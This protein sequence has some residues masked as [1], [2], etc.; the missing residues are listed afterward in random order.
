MLCR[1]DSSLSQ[2][3]LGEEGARCKTSL[4]R[5]TETLIIKLE[6]SQTQAEQLRKYDRSRRNGNM[7]L[8][9]PFCFRE[10]FPAIE[11]ERVR[12]IALSA[13]M[14]MSYMRAQDDT[15]DRNTSVDPLILFVRDLYLRE[16]LHLLYALFPAE[17][18]FW[19]SYS[20][21]FNQ[22][23]TSVLR[24]T[25]NH[26]AARSQY[27][28]EE[29]CAIAKGKAA[30]AK[31]PVAAL[32]ELSGSSEKVSL[33][34]ES[35]DCFHVGY[36]YWDDVVDWK[37]DLAASKY[38]LLLSR[39][40]ERSTSEDLNVSADRLQEIIGCAVYFGGLAESNLQESYRWLQQ[41][42]DLAIKAGCTIWA[43]YVYRLQKQ[44]ANLANDLRSLM[45]SK[46]V[47]MDARQSFANPRQP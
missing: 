29:F 45:T 31:F 9:F 11:V 28:V 46:K 8:H 5:F 26:F 41:S 20:A 2:I 42:A 10:A 3:D 7:Y 17:S 23:A 14:W 35:L 22:Y 25:Q 12:I 33:L 34:T 47:E 24:E 36:Q 37:E 40:T 4:E 6:L 19:N 30:M 21:Y 16:S 15:I 18:K 39:A 38:S 1:N 44:T 43:N 32:A 27:D 13:V